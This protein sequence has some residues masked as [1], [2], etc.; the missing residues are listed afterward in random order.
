MARI[1][2]GTYKFFF[3][4]GRFFFKAQQIEKFVY[5]YLNIVAMK[6]Y[7]GRYLSIAGLF[8]SHDVS[9]V[10]KDTNLNVIFSTKYLCPI[11][12]RPSKFINFF[13]YGVWIFLK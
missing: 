3:S 7:E 9:D 10:M 6:L 11:A 13:L 8:V 12:S 4:K 1:S 2:L 5:L